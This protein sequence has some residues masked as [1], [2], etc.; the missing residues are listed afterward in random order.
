MPLS[1]NFAN[2]LAMFY[3]KS[4]ETLFEFAE[5]LTISRS[6]LQAILSSKAN[7]TLATVE[8]V[9]EKLD[10]DPIFLLSCSRE[11]TE[12]FL[13]LEQLVKL[14]LNLPSDRKEEF[15]STFYRLFLLL[16]DH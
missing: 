11:D 3:E 2:N 8:L 10:V 5:R 7:P 6:Y 4:N 9:A 14:F 13:V 1:K 15:T 12:K 16:M